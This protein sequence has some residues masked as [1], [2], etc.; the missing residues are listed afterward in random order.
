MRRL[1]R[2]AAR[3]GYRTIEGLVLAANAPMLALARHLGFAVQ[4]LPG[5]TTVST[6]RR[7]L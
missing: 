2:R 6:V 1:M 4:A 3:D 5:D 7:R